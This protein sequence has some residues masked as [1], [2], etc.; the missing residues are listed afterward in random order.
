M[1][2]VQ[3]YEYTINMKTIFDEKLSELKSFYCREDFELSLS[4]VDRAPADAI[5]HRMTDLE[6]LCEARGIDAEKLILDR[7][8]LDKI[9]TREQMQENLL[10][11]FYDMYS[12]F[13]KTTDFMERIVR[14]LAPEYNNDTVRTAILKK[15]LVGAGKKF[16][17]FNTKNI[18]EWGE[19]RLSRSERDL[20][21]S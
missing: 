20:L 11:A 14:R 5:K 18:M 12:E 9:P 16:K 6:K 21:S 3:P 13:P 4:D 2:S 17:R 10:Q 7:T 15:F 19:K 1:T 8:L